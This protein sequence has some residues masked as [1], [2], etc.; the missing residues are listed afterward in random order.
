MARAVRGSKEKGAPDIVIERARAKVKGIVQ[1]VGFRPFVYQLASR[2]QLAGYVTNT[3]EGVDIEIEG[4][5]EKVANFFKVLVENPPP[6]AHISS[7]KWDKV[8]PRGESQFLI[9]KSQKRGERSTLISPDVCVCHDCLREMMDPTDR[10]YRYPFINCTNCGPRYTIIMDIPYD[11]ATTTMKKFIMCEEC[12]REYHDPSDRRFHAQPNACWACG[13]RVSLYRNDRTPIHTQ[14]PIALAASLLAKG[15]IVAVKGLGGFHLAVDAQNHGA[16]ARLRRKKHREEKPLAVMVRDM[17]VAHRLAHIDEA[18]ASLLTSAQR[19]IVLVKKRL[20]HGLSPQVSPRNKYLGIM[21]PYTPL[22]H[23]LMEVGPDVLVMTSGNMTDE[24]INIDNDSAFDNLSHIADFFLIHDREIYLR[25]DDSVLRVI[26]G[27]ARQIRR[28]R[29]YVPVPLF[30]PS[31]SKGMPSVL[32]VG[33]ELKNTVCLTKEN[34]AFLSQHIGDMENLE[35]YDFFQLTIRHLQNILEITPQLIAHDLHP[36]YLSTLYAKDEADLP[37]EGVQH[38]HA[39]IVSCMAE[40]GLRGPVIGL[41]MDGTGYGLDGR[42]WGCEF[43]VS[44]LVSFIRIGHL[45]YIPLPGGDLAAKYPWRMGLV[46][47]FDAFGDELFDLPIPFIRNLDM[48]E[49]TIVLSTAQKGINSPL[50]SSCG[51]LFDAV[52]AILGL[53]NKN[54]YEGQAAMELEMIQDELVTQTY[55][56]EIAEESQPVG[57]KMVLDPRPTI[58]A[59][60]EEIRKGVD[61]GVVSRKFHNTLIQQFTEVTL[62]IRDHTGIRQVVMSGGCFQNA[63]LL[64]GLSRIL[65]QHGFETYTH[66]MVPTNDGGV[67][68]GQALCAGM[69]KLQME[70]EA[71]RKGP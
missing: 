23:L 13:P 57:V 14:D 30:L 9:L 64:A 47:L 18:E 33:G 8:P 12:E 42:I 51:R 52:S 5:P 55:P 49:A 21:L 24:P 43:L 28:S 29:G 59:M 67:S 19:P 27:Q 50:S 69:R 37:L 20:A 26:D 68:L 15:H 63:T 71:P 70:W 32:A 11:R 7:L 60:V 40:H 2:L 46:Y 16:V 25:S 6:L 61:K 48:E 56:Y 22:H 54:A 31:F 53:R 1:G 45:R 58:R 34:L 17:D 65:G 66:R 62:R 38:H 35:T 10:R 44:D 39:H 41:A 3:P 4:S 36:D